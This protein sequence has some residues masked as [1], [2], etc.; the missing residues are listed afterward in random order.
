MQVIITSPSLNT[1]DNVS[2]ISAVTQFIASHNT[3][4][5][6]THCVFGKKDREA[7]NLMWLLRTLTSYARWVYV[8][9]IQ[10]RAIVHFNLALDL[11]SLIRDLPLIMV[12]RLFR[13]RVII[14][15]H[16]GEFLAGEGMPLWLKSVLRLTLAR[17]PIIVLSQLEQALIERRTRNAKIFVLPN[18][19]G[20]EEAKAFERAYPSDEPLTLLFLGRITESKG[21]D[22]LYQGL[23]A[24]REKG[25]RFRFV[26]AGA[27]PDEALYVRKFRELLG[28]D[29]DFR[30]VVAGTEK[31]EVL[32]KCN[33][34]V[35][36]SLC[37][38]GM[39]IALLEG[40]A[41]GL[42]PVTTGVGSI[43]SVI[44]HG[45]NGIIV[46]A[47]S[48][49]EIVDA[50]DTLAADKQYMQALSKNGRQYIWENCRPDRYLR[51]LNAIYQYE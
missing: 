24:L 34:F 19:I 26:L 5:K 31:T 48:P 18:C 16:G 21:L 10:T 25:A 7:R 49:G 8:I 12:A 27:G 17:G 23:T 44:T 42:V 33:V 36:P 45:S 15:I 2:G 20:V 37:G 41:F 13:R 29:F 35:L 11:R 32:K 1:A 9:L 47:Q 28:E 14:H 39:P 3:C 30:G 46:G 51:T 43:P 22:V 4:C 40:M 38:E 50:I 6:Y